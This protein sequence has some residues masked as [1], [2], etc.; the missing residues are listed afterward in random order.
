MVR[1]YDPDIDESGSNTK[2]GILRG[3]R[4]ELS[5][6]FFDGEE[7]PAMR[8]REME[9][10]NNEEYSVVVDIEVPDNLRGAE[11]NQYAENRMARAAS[12]GNVV[13]WKL[14]D[15]PEHPVDHDLVVNGSVRNRNI[16]WL[17][18]PDEN[19]APAFRR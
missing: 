9:R 1:R 14:A 4:S 19:A 15:Y 13:E 5:F 17:P 18:A 7:T 6:Y 16:S 12:K 8:F 11:F 3:A 2:E 10:V